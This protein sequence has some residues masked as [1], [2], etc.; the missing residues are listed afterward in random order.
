MDT[1]EQLTHTHITPMTYS[2]PISLKIRT[3]TKLFP[4]LLRLRASNL[5]HLKVVP[6][7]FLRETCPDYLPLSSLV[8]KGV[9]VVLV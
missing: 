8:A 7:S 4:Q 6:S 3:K 2:F 5:S 1:T 9:R